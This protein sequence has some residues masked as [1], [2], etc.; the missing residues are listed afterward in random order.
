[1]RPYFESAGFK[2]PE[3]PPPQP[4]AAAQP[5]PEAKKEEKKIKANVGSGSEAAKKQEGLFLRFI[6][7][8]VDAFDKPAVFNDYTRAV[9]VN[10]A[11]C[12]NYPT[13]YQVCL[14]FILKKFFPLKMLGKKAIQVKK[15]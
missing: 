15:T 7:V 6:V 14:F 3:N 4:I 2:L 13:F 11:K 9:M 5:Q 1:M 8:L 12:M 10:Y